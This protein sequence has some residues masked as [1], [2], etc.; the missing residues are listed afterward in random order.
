V[1]PDIFA[2]D[3]GLAAYC[4]TARG[5]ARAPSPQDFRAEERFMQRFA[6]ILWPVEQYGFRG[7]HVKQ[8]VLNRKI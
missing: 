1:R 5:R 2:C 4:A 7:C 3:D 6:A 8:A